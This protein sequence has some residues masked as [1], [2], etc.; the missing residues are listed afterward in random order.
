MPKLKR[1]PLKQL[2]VHRE[3]IKEVLQTLKANL[4]KQLTEA[5]D[6]FDT[7]T[8]PD[9]IKADDLLSDSKISNILRAFSISPSKRTAKGSKNK[10]GIT[11]GKTKKVSVRELILEVLK[12]GKEMT[13]PQI[14][15]AI[16]AKT[17]KKPS[18][19]YHYVSELVKEEVLV[20]KDGVFKL[21]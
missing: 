8:S 21:K 14:S 16:E 11:A 10:I 15:D 2:Q 12:G 3:A 5:K 20:E 17:G 13:R 18:N 19:V 6:T 7:L 4:L 1:N 9:G